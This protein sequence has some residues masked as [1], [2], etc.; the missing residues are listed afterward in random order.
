M[1]SPYGPSFLYYIFSSTLTFDYNF[2]GFFKALE[3]L[4]YTIVYLGG[5][6]LTY[7]FYG[8]YYLISSFFYYY[9]GSS[10]LTSGYFFSSIFYFILIK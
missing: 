1:I 4:F 9:F 6:C 3:G 8:G 5:S 7:S 10:F 2:G